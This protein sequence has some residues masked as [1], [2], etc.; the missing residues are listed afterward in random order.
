[1]APGTHFLYNNWDFN[2]LGTILERRTGQTVYALFESALARPIGLQ[3]WISDRATQASMVRN[4]TGLS[5]HPAHHFVLS[6]R[7]MARLGQL[8]LRGGRWDDAQVIPA[9][10]V[11]RTTSTTTS[12]D[13]V[14]RTSPFVPGLGYGFLWWTFDSAAPDT[15]LHG[16]YTASGA[17]GQFITVI[18]ALDMVVVHKTAVPPPRN[19]PA[20]TYFGTI[21]PQVIGLR[22]EPE[23]GR[24]GLANAARPAPLPQRGERLHSHPVPG[25]ARVRHDGIIPRQGILLGGETPA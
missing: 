24:G 15:P 9:D 17:F 23:R 6:T 16:A 10:W 18:P 4:D 21:L 2:A 11:A 3:D 1:V 7:D 22:A 19:L 25:A 12:A 13:T 5:V 20:E 8:M 14:A